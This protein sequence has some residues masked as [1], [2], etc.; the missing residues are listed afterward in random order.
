MVEGKVKCC[1]SSMF[2]KK[3]F[4]AGYHLRVVKGN[5]FN[6]Q[7]FEQTLK[8]YLPKAHLHSEIQTEMIYAL[9]SGDS[10]QQNSTAVFPQLF[11]EI[12][13]NKDKLGISSCG[14]SITTMEDVFIRVGNEFEVIDNKKNVINEIKD[15]SKETLVHKKSEYLTGF[16]LV[17]HQFIGLL[18]KRFHYAKRYWTMMVFQILVP[19]AL[20]VVALLLNNSIRSSNIGKTKNLVLDIKEL[21]GNTNGFSKTTNSK[22][23]ENFYVKNAKTHGMN[24]ERLGDRDPNEWALSHAHDLDDYTEHYL[25]GAVFD[26]N[27]TIN[28]EVWYNNEALHSLPISINLMFESLLKYVMQNNDTKPL[29]SVSNHPIPPE[30][31]EMSN[32]NQIMAGWALTCLLLIPITVPFLGASYV[33]FPINENITKAKLLQLMTGLSSTLFWFSN[34]VFD[35]MNHSIAVFI[36]YIIFAIFDS[37][38]VFF[39]NTSTAVGILLLLF[40]F[41]FASIPLAYCFSLVFKK[42]TTGFAT[43]W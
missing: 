13:K 9:E 39:S 12:E 34:F 41:G 27:G 21:Y 40:L 11:D 2:L 17:C 14:L 7:T 1:G 18:F 29:I 19:A 36:I 26:Q 38:R 30:K 23:I 5:G 42:P 3:R 22:D 16:P 20:F 28:A 43:L 4:G 6:S 15:K 8:K 10:N 33:L 37:N 31:Q 25:I 32:I 24:V 35:L